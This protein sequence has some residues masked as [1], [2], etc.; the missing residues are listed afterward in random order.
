MGGGTKVFAASVVALSRCSVGTRLPAFL[1]Q[2]VLMR[3]LKM[4][5][6]VKVGRLGD[7]RGAVTE[8]FIPRRPTR[9]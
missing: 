6:G 7:S 2:D 5:A 3:R 4:E 8:R 9:N 1:S